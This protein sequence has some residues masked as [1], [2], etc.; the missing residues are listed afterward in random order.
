[1]IKYTYDKKKPVLAGKGLKAEP[2]D[3]LHLL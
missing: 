1:M 3:V 2:L